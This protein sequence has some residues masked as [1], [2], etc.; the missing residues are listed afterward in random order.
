M[1]RVDQECRAVGGGGGEERRERDEA[2]EKGGVGGGRD[3]PA[4][5]ARRGAATK[6][7]MGS[8]LSMSPSPCATTSQGEGSTADPRRRR[9][10]PAR[11]QSPPNRPPAA[12]RG[13]AGAVLRHRQVHICFDAGPLRRGEPAKTRSPLRGRHLPAA[14]RWCARPPTRPWERLGDTWATGGAAATT[15][16]EQDGRQPCRRRRL[17]NKAAH[18]PRPTCAPAHTQPPPPRTA[19][20]ATCAAAPPHCLLGTRDC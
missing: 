13:Q 10:P 15:K 12:S 5:R 2:G 20:D 7:F 17:A 14:G 18:P 9:P 1:L 11:Q 3:E 16:R 4:R 8:R 19:R 6:H